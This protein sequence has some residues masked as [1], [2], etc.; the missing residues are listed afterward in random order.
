MDSISRSSSSSA[1]VSGYDTSS[2]SQPRAAAPSNK[3][4]SDDDSLSEK[5]GHR[6]HKAR[7]G[8][9]PRRKP[10]MEEVDG[11]APINRL[12]KER[13]KRVPAGGAGLA[14]Y[15]MSEK[16]F[17]AYAHAMGMPDEICESLIQDVH[18]FV[19]TIV[20]LTDEETSQIKKAVDD[21]ESLKKIPIGSAACRQLGTTS[22]AGWAAYL[23]SFFLGKLAQNLST[24]PSGSVHGGWSFLLAGVLNPLVTEPIAQGIRSGGVTHASPDGKAYM[25]YHTACLWLRQVDGNKDLKKKW[26]KERAD[27]VSEVLKREHAQ[28]MHR[29]GSGIDEITFDKKTHKPISARTREGNAIKPKEAMNQ[30]IDAARRRAYITDELPFFTFTLNYLISGALSP[31]LKAGLTTWNYLG[32][33]LGLSALMGSLS[34]METAVTQNWLRA[35]IQG[36]Q[37]VGLTSKRKRALRNVADTELTIMVRKLNELSRIRTILAHQERY[38]ETK[39]KEGYELNDELQALRSLQDDAKQAQKSVRKKYRQC[40]LKAKAYSSMAS[41]RADIVNTSMAT[42]MGELSGNTESFKAEAM[43]FRAAAKLI[44]YPLSLVPVILYNT[45]AA[46]AIVNAFTPPSAQPSATNT[47]FTPTSFTHPTSAPT[48]TS[49]TSIDSAVLTAQMV[50]AALS[51]IPLIV[52]FTLRQQYLTRFTETA[53]VKL[54]G[55]KPRKNVQNDT[56]SEASGG[57]TKRTSGADSEKDND[58]NDDA[59]VVVKPGADTKKLASG[60]SSAKKDDVSVVISDDDD[61]DSSS[62]SDTDKG[63]RKSVV[64]TGT[65]SG[66]ESESDQER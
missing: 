62:S 22:M 33:D 35:Y 32:A 3:T 53:L 11:S 54:F 55:S 50:A 27:I 1:V 38:L 60:K 21:A 45:L 2:E 18:K 9:A 34:G 63:G 5:Q 26:R 56:A 64:V 36:A 30:V 13:R 23:T 14:T 39:I 7:P 47:T 41:Q 15:G 17:R 52:G 25:D 57:A 24:I 28:Q 59:G 19:Q 65:S 4:N 49:T 66:S 46:P 20:D 44:A 8:V 48:S 10:R 31:L 12:E 29:L 43:T 42:Y 58:G 6:K 40:K 61:E 16:Q 51:G 37:K